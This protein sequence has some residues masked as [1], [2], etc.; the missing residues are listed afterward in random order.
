M[1]NTAHKETIINR[2]ITGGGSESCFGV[3]GRIGIFKIAHG[4]EVGHAQGAHPG[5]CRTMGAKHMMHCACGR[6]NIAQPRR[7]GPFKM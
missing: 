7:M 1:K 2:V 5:N 3:I 4:S 6:A